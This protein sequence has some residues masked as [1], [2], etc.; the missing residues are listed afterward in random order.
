MVWWCCESFFVVGISGVIGN[1]T[2]PV[3]KEGGERRGSVLG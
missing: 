1:L 2:S 3:E